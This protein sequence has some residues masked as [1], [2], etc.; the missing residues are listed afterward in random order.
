MEENVY[1]FS[2]RVIPERALI[3]VAE[4][5]FRT[6]ENADVPQ[7]RLHVQIFRSQI[8]VRY[9][10]SGEVK[11][12]LSLRNLVE[13]AVRTILDVA[14]YHAGYGYDA[15]ITQVVRPLSSY[16]HVFGIDVPALAG[17]VTKSGLTIQGIFSALA[18]SDGNYLREALADTR[19]AIKS[20]RD[21]GF[22]VTEQLN[23][24]RIVV[25]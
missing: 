20:P 23:R 16:I 25:L 5:G 7:G 14:G 15:E 18:K 10:C 21:T 8:S 1:V 2:G 19:E 4:V 3:D 22:F 9:V 12:I 17:L 13:D 11:N 24:L 6:V